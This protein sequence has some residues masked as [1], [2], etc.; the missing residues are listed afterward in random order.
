MARYRI[1]K[2]GY[3]EEMEPERR[4]R[5]PIALTMDLIRY[6]KR[7][8]QEFE[9]DFHSQVEGHKSYYEDE[10]DHKQLDLQMRRNQ[11]FVRKLYSGLIMMAIL[12]L[13]YWLFKVIGG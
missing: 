8:K 13:F 5:G 4:K 7:K 11:V 1:R 3:H 9:D 10:T 12:A 2:N 6:V